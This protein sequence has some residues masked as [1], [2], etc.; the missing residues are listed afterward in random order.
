MLLAVARA[1]V[2]GALLLLG[3]AN[4]ENVVVL[5]HAGV[6]DLLLQLVLAAEVGV[7]GKALQVEDALHL[8]RVVVVL[9]G[10][11]TTGQP[12]A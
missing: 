5:R 10:R 7:G 12:C 6:A 11:G 3:A 9:G 4:H 2:D 8:G 1:D